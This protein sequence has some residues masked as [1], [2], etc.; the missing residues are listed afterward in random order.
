MLSCLVAGQQG[1][2]SGEPL[3]EEACRMV[4]E[5]Q[6]VLS[7]KGS[8]SASLAE[9]WKAVS[10]DRCASNAEAFWQGFVNQPWRA[11]HVIMMLTCCQ[12]IHLIESSQPRPQC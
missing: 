12:T 10:S 4:G 8:T 1:S 3:S 2:D 5:L 6:H 7:G 11:M 9:L